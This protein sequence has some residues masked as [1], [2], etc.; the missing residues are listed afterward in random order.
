MKTFSLVLFTFL[1]TQF[2][3]ANVFI[4]EQGII[5]SVG[6]SWPSDSDNEHSLKDYFITS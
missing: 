3:I 1:L 6:H 5:R 2:A 4:D